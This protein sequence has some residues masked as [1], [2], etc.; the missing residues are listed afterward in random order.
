MA[1]QRSRSINYKPLTDVFTEKACMVYSIDVPDIKRSEI[2]KVF[3]TNTKTAQYFHTNE[4]KEYVKFK[5]IYI[6]LDNSEGRGLLTKVKELVDSVLTTKFEPDVAT[7]NVL[8]NGEIEKTVTINDTIIVDGSISLD[9]HD[10][11]R[12]EFGL[13]G[14][15]AK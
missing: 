6:P 7:I 14:I 10:Y 9:L 3:N 11:V 5:V 4:K 1:E 8:R 13:S 12:I 15:L 2:V